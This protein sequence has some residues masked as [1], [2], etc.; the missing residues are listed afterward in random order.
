M[1]ALGFISFMHGRG[2][3]QLYFQIS[4][5]LKCVFECFTEVCNGN[6]FIVVCETIK[7]K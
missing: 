4:G 7:T 3:I 5:L 1:T 6:V 2:F